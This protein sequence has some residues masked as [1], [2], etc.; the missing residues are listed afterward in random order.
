[1]TDTN[2]F[3]L[4]HTAQL[5]AILFAASDPTPIGRLATALELTPHQI[6]NL[7]DD[8]QEE[9][10]TRGLSLQWQNDAV[11]LTTAPETSEAVERFL[12]LSLTTRLSGASLETLAIVAYMQP[13]T[14]PHIDQIRGVSSDGALRTL[15]N[16][17]LIEEQGR[18]D[19]PGRPILYGTTL[20]FL[21]QFGLESLNELP[22]ITDEE[23]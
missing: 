19:T 15:L 11:Q 12:G 6:N 13:V 8:L 1:M 20:T 3:S 18:M 4:S 7:L 21:Q 5:E 14:R 10:V 17:D 22:P 16:H 2:P 9:Y 23:E